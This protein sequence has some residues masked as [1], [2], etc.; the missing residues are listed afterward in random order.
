MAK[1]S[2]RQQQIIRRLAAGE[3]QKSIA[4][5]LGVSYSTVRAHMRQA[6]E[7]TDTRTSLELAI[8]AEQEIR[9]T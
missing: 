8:K 1:L 4:R 9:N 3:S 5:Q 2:P 7:R 6:R